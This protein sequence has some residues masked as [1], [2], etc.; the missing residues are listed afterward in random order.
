MSERRCSVI[1]TDGTKCERAISV[2]LER[3]G[4]LVCSI[5]APKP[6]TF[7]EAEVREI[8]AKWMERCADELVTMVNLGEVARV[9]AWARDIRSGK[10]NLE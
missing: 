6:H 2:Q 8:A 10:E 3:E 5:H 7:T 9:R 4:S 1:Y